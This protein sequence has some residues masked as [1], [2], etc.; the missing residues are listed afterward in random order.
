MSD[1]VRDRHR[2]YSPRLQRPKKTTDNEVGEKWGFRLM[3][4]FNFVE[5]EISTPKGRTGLFQGRMARPQGSVKLE[6]DNWLK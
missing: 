1:V 6:T 5:G 2:R 4:L 3:C